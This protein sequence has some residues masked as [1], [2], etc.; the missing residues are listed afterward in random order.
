VTVH[1]VFQKLPL[2]PED[3]ERL[4]AAYEIALNALGLVDR[5]DPA[6]NL[7]AKIVIEVYQ[8]GMHDPE[9]VAELTVRRLGPD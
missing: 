1:R 2:Q 5:A 9:Q 8:T 4:E 6:T 7:V 3:I